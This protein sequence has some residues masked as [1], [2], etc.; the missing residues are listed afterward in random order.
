MP[1]TSAQLLKEEVV[2]IVPDLVFDV[3]VVLPSYFAVALNNLAH[4]DRD[5]SRKFRIA[6]AGSL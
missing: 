3:A 5:V 1:P 4:L 2:D 6:D